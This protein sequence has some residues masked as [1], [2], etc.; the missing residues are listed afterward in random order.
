MHV[1]YRLDTRRVLHLSVPAFTVPPGEGQADAEVP[2]APL[3]GPAGDLRLTADLSALE[4][5]PATVPLLFAG[6]PV[7]G[8]ADVDRVTTRRIAGH[9]APQ[10][11]GDPFMQ[12]RALLRQLEDVAAARDTLEDPAATQA[13]RDQADAILAAARTRRAQ[14][15][16]YRQEGADF[17]AAR[18]W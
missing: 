10:W 12:T 13:L 8:A 5:D 14:V 2:D 15:L 6:E 17:K 4:V 18:G 11:A 16:A 7:R 9:L 1:R 3:P